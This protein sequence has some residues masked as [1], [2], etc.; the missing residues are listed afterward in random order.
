MEID[1][2]LLMET[3]KERKSARGRSY[4]FSEILKTVEEQP[5]ARGEEE[6]LDAQMGTLPARTC[7][8]CGNTIPII[9]GEDGS[10]IL[11]WDYCSKCGCH[12][13]MQHEPQWAT[14]K[15]YCE[16]WGTREDT[17]RIMIR[18]GLFKNYK[19][20]GGATWILDITEKPPY[21]NKPK[22]Q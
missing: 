22:K 18:R 14:V 9:I 1:R 6:W 5:P 12:M 21:G 2:E 11:S 10:D 15:E 7:S 3:L 16:K 20:L 8:A 19:K 17:V 13:K 4:V